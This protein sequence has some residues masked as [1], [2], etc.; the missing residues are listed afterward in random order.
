[1]FWAFV[2]PLFLYEVT[3]TVQ[4][5]LIIS[6][7]LPTL[8]LLANF[9]ATESKLRLGDWWHSF[10]VTAIYLFVN[11]LFTIYEEAPVYPFMTW[12]DP[13]TSLYCF[14]CWLVGQACTVATAYI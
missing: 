12:S 1:M 9:F 2:A 7:T 8:L 13:Y 5:A 14:G 4:I 10:F 6:H 3:L 11:Y